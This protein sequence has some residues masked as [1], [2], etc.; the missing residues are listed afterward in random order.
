MKELVPLELV[1]QAV[2]AD[3]FDQDDALLSHYRDTAVEVVVRRINRDERDLLEL[4]G[5]DLPLGLKQAVL[6]LVGHWY[7]QREEATM[8]QMYSIPMG[9]EALV[10]PYQKLTL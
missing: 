3:D 6:L 8:G 5:G 7:N 2:R 4:G 1:K 10:R 9:F